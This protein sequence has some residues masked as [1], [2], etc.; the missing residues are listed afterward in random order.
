M[1]LSL[2][3]HRRLHWCAKP[4]LLL[5]L[6]LLICGKSS[7]RDFAITNCKTSPDRPPSESP[8]EPGRANPVV[9]PSASANRQWPAKVILSARVLDELHV[10]HRAWSPF[11]FA[12]DTRQHCD[13]PPRA[14]CEGRR[15]DMNDPQQKKQAHI[16]RTKPVIRIAST[17]LVSILAPQEQTS[18][19]RLNSIEID[20]FVLTRRS[21]QHLSPAV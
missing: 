3:R 12:G 6:V 10:L 16:A 14:W 19:T 17:L 18:M 9:C 11:S 15:L 20:A 4:R 21:D 7:Q 13:C 8:F 5:A 2:Q 1:S